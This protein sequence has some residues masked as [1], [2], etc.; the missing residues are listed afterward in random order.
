MACVVCVCMCVSYI[1][2]HW[3]VYVCDEC[4]YTVK[5]SLE[6]NTIIFICFLYHFPFFAD[7]FR[8]PHFFIL[9]ALFRQHI[10]MTI[11]FCMI[12][13]HACVCVCELLTIIYSPPFYL[14]IKLFYFIFWFLLFLHI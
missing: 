4:M 14:M 6:V 2:E 10:H 12:Y 1:N 13:H 5:T 3:N 9:L 7:S 11:Y 8:F